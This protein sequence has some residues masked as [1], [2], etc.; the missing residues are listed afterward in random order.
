MGQELK[1]AAAQAPQLPMPS[2][3][4]GRTVSIVGILTVFVALLG[5]VREASLAARFGASAGMD[6]YFAAVFIPMMLY[7]ILVTGTLSPIFITIFLH[8]NALAD[9]ERASETFSI[10][11]NFTLLLLAAVTVGAMLTIRWWLPV[12]F[13]GFDPATQDLTVRL[14]YIVLPT[15]LLLGFSGI[16]T[17]VLNGLHRFALAAFA[18][19][20]SSIVVIFA[21]VL[22]R[23]DQAL[24]WV[25]AATA[26]GFLVPC[27]VLFPVIRSLGIRY[28]PLLSLKHPALIKMVRLGLPL[29]LYLMAAY[30]PNLIER[31]LASGIATG[32]VAALSYALRLFSVPSGF[33]A[34][35]LATVTYPQFAQHAASDSR[36][37]LAADFY[38]LFR[39]VLFLFV[40]ITVGLCLNA[41]PITQVLYQHGHFQLR[42]AWM[43]SE[44]LRF[45]CL[46]VLPNALAIIFLRCFFAFQDTVTPLVAELIDLAYYITAGTWLAH[47]LGL[48]G[49]AIARAGTFYVV[50]AV[51]CLVA[52]KKLRI[53]RI[54]R[55]L[56]NLAL[57]TLV[58]TAGMALMIRVS[59]WLAQGAFDSTNW[60]FKAAILA[61]VLALAAATFIGASVA[62][63]VR[64]AAHILR[65]VRNLVV[66]P[67][68]LRWEKVR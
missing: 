1:A 11:T 33:L 27:I 65:T 55:D 38:K 23:G 37:Q 42:D 32:A 39:I 62:M 12:L 26:F 68:A 3:P 18:P 36:E 64:E 50:T 57:R 45:Y 60:V 28:R 46:G 51:L 66:Q 9:R 47:H 41:V 17:A 59:W 8:E 63:Q 35:P 34:V 30:V 13:A 61:G 4:K 2:A 19:G 25:A 49:L 53:F 5:Y 67:P 14:T 31:H 58:A 56:V 52:W 6:A 48:A 54:D 40:P 44:V 22:A 24:Y 21:V 16:L 10:M 29:L 15:V 43:T 7:L 20:L